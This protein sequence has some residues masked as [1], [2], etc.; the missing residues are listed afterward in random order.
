MPR[1][2][3]CSHGHTWTGDMG[4][5]L[6]CP[7]CQSTDVYEYRIVGQIDTTQLPPVMPPTGSEGAPV[8]PSPSPSPDVYPLAPL[9]KSSLDSTAIQMTALGEPAAAAAK[10]APPS[11]PRRPIPPPPPKRPVPPPPPVAGRMKDTDIFPA[12][13]SP[14]GG[15]TYVLPPTNPADQSTVDL[16]AL[17][18]E[19]GDTVQFEAMAAADSG[20]TVLLDGRPA[21][22]TASD[23]TI[24]VDS[25]STDDWSD[26][27]NGT[28]SRADSSTGM[29]TEPASS[30][31]TV[32]EES[33]L[34]DST[35]EFT[36]A[37]ETPDDP[38]STGDFTAV[39]DADNGST[40][41]FTAVIDADNGS[42]GDFTAVIDADNGST[43]DFT[44]VVDPV[45]DSAMPNTEVVSPESAV[46]LG[47][48]GTRVGPAFDDTV[49]RVAQPRPKAKPGGKHQPPEV[50]GYDILG[51]LGRGGMGV[52]Y[53]ARQKG[54]QRLVA[55]KMILGGAHAG[56][57]DKGRFRLEAEAVA[58]LQHRNIV[59]IYDIGERDGLPFFSLEYLDG[60]SLQ[61]RANGQPMPPKVAAE[62]V[63]QLADAMQ[64][65]HERGIIHRDLK[66]QNVL[67]QKAP[68]GSRTSVHTS[69]DLKPAGDIP[70]ITDFGLA[71]KIEGDSG[72]TGT[73]AILGTPSFMSPEQADGRTK[74][75]GPPTDIHALGAILYDL[76]TGRPPFLGA[77]PMDTI[78]QVRNL[79]P[80][81]PTR[82]NP[83]TPLDL[84]NIV[85]KCL[86]KEMSKRYASAGA[87]ADDLR[88][89]VAD[90][91]VMARPT[92]A[93]EKAYKWAKRRPTAAAVVGLSTLLAASL[94]VGSIALARSE[95][96]YAES[97][98]QRAD[99]QEKTA[100][101]ETKLRELANRQR[102]R[103]EDNLK[104]MRQALDE[105]LTRIGD[106]KLR[107]VPALTKIRGELLSRATAIYDEALKGEADLDLVREA[108]WAQQRAGRVRE[109][110]GEP[111]EAADAYRKAAVLFEKLTATG[112]E[113]GDRKNLADTHRLLTTVAA[114]LDLAAE[115]D[116][117]F[118]VAQDLLG[119]L[120]QEFPADDIYRLE[121]AAL[122]NSRGAVL[123][124]RRRAAE[125]E[126]AFR[127]AT[128]IFSM[129][130]TPDA[131]LE[132][133]R[134]RINLGLM[135]LATGRPEDAVSELR[136]GRER[137]VELLSKYPEDQRYAAELSRAANLS[138]VAFWQAGHYDVAEE[139]LAAAAK[140]FGTLSA[141][142]PDNL[143]YRFEYAKQRQNL[144]KL[145][146]DTGKPT[147]AAERTQRVSY[148]G[149]WPTND[150]P[151]STFAR[152]TASL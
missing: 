76:L 56:D 72:F 117:S 41:D 18:P 121:L 6:A 107:D 83:R 31:G 34:H 7:H 44:A 104:R 136:I 108:G 15:E 65:A 49:S 98:R 73:G 94:L 59:A 30:T 75:I 82:W 37:T 36:I 2:W 84:E 141:K 70:K 152:L 129:V 47:Q 12:V 61:D 133:A 78:M 137:I 25:P 142:F 8:K 148:S 81:P 135:L 119:S 20:G 96:M 122:W 138:G 3:R 105:L 53:K 38:A 132:A 88:R 139:A 54:L 58:Q 52:V 123:G 87:L 62:I 50:E 39:I 74:E 77:D 106:Q 22:A 128:D 64:Y 95:K 63:A 127:K 130:S 150:L 115:S 146:A 71:K 103:A 27:M 93:W 140:Q 51:V 23:A 16:P 86:Q 80:V 55:L 149:S 68:E 11:K 29:W 147:A 110:L 28:P 116:K 85:L 126:A 57:A 113:P 131:T 111:K 124:D 46:R 4:A 21:P 66:P 26:E 67:F 91:P 17:P 112:N 35:G 114:S 48:R 43:G 90:E 102:G 145:L 45:G 101:K 79:D 118:D 24:V 125:A 109:A 144:A 92:P 42:T 33:S 13:R 97:Q 9:T 14:G 10:P 69:G 151:I 120:I 40:G 89:F 143:D 134:T 1:N 99:E 5:L 60:G 32:N 100:L 19:A